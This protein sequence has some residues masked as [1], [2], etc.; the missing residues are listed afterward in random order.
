MHQSAV[1]E[2]IRRG[3][4]GI[5]RRHA[6][7]Q[8]KKENIKQYLQGCLGWMA[9]R[10]GVSLGYKTKSNTKLNFEQKSVEVSVRKITDGSK[11]K[12]SE[13]SCSPRKRF[14][15]DNDSSNEQKTSSN[16]SSLFGGLESR[17]NTNK[18]DLCIKLVKRE[19]ILGPQAP[20]F[21]DVLISSVANCDPPLLPPVEQLP[22]V[23]LPPW[24][25]AQVQELK[26]SV[27]GL[28]EK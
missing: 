22:P 2:Q 17:S 19:V 26:E 3:N 25:G 7:K 21:P 11:I 12:S 10:S 15:W 4:T 16:H 6:K 20:E 5:V 13:Q 24:L 27:E 1:Q 8:K 28:I 9:E 14:D 23:P 18:S